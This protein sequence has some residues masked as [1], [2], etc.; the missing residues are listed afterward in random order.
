MPRPRRRRT[1]PSEGIV[2]SLSVGFLP[3][4]NAGTTPPRMHPSSA[5][6]TWTRSPG[7]ELVSPRSASSVPPAYPDAVVTSVEYQTIDT[8]DGGLISKIPGRVI[9]CRQAKI[10][11]PGPVVYRPRGCGKRPKRASRGENGSDGLQDEPG[12]GEEDRAVG[13]GARERSSEVARA[14]ATLAI[15]LGR[16]LDEAPRSGRAGLTRSLDWRPATAEP[17][18]L[19]GRSSPPTIRGH[20][21]SRK[22]S[23]PDSEVESP[24]VP[25]TCHYAYL[26]RGHSPIT[27]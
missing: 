17:S 15:S 1:T 12:S 11:D 4:D 27:R 18:T 19:Y 7:P 5:R 8:G 24:G 2:S 6:R 26:N 9:F 22:S 16:R 20:R 14:F 21:S 13:R 25:R 23:T 3:H 10:H